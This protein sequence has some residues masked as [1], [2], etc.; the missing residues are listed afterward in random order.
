VSRLIGGCV[1]GLDLGEGAISRT[2]SVGYIA[3]TECPSLYRWLGVGF[4]QNVWN[5]LADNA[6][7]WW[8]SC[9][10]EGLTGSIAGGVIPFPDQ[11]D[12]AM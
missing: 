8:I 6:V 1:A 11:N 9:D 12:L 2:I 10:C 3:V 5:V 7:K 4:E